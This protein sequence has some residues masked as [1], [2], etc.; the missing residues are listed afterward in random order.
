MSEVG[1]FYTNER[2]EGISGYMIILIIIIIVAIVL[3]IFYLFHTSYANPDTISSLLI[4]NDYS[5]CLVDEKQGNLIYSLEREYHYCKRGDEPPG[6]DRYVYTSDVIDFDLPKIIYI[7]SDVDQIIIHR[8]GKVHTFVMKIPD[9]EYCK[10]HSISSEFKNPCDIDPV[11][12][13]QGMELP[14]TFK[15]SGNICYYN[16]GQNVDDFSAF[17]SHIPAKSKRFHETKVTPV[18]YETMQ[19]RFCPTHFVSC[20]GSFMLQNTFLSMDFFTDKECDK[21]LEENETELPLGTLSAMKKIVPGAFKADL[22]RYCILYINGGVYADIKLVCEKSLRKYMN[23]DLTLVQDRETV[24]GRLGIYNAF[25]IC[26]KG[27]KLMYAAIE[28]CVHRINNN[29]YGD[30]ALDIT[31]PLALGDVVIKYYKLRDPNLHLPKGLKS[32]NYLNPDGEMEYMHV[33]LHNDRKILD[34]TKTLIKTRVD[35]NVI[36]EYLA[37]SRLTNKKHYSYYWKDRNVYGEKNEKK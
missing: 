33:L 31:G 36:S 21:F 4:D 20:M 35:G 34:G 14:E 6:F 2:K 28:E 18:L 8:D 7:S 10:P 29:Y 13:F 12:R 16:L 27:H 25:I 30:S 9:R 26:K 32:G 5:I 1:E 23:Y 11:Q 37:V 24:P 22:F 19:S 15:I 3:V 17:P